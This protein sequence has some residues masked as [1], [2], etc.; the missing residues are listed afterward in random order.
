MSGR[1]TIIK[2]ELLATNKN[3]S[4]L[5]LTLEDLKVSDKVQTAHLNRQLILAVNIVYLFQ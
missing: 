4:T 2:L 1:L 5:G 3:G